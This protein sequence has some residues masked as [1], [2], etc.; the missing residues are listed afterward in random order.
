M[1]AMLTAGCRT[2]EVRRKPVVT[3]VPTGSELISLEEFSET[4]P[5]GKTIESNSAVLAGMAHAIG[6]EPKVNPIVA[7]DYDTLK[8]TLNQLVASDTDMVVINA[9]SWCNHYAGQADHPGL[10]Q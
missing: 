10:Y 6:A 3:I 4:P 7:D 9:G 2:V 5:P 1:A 8:A